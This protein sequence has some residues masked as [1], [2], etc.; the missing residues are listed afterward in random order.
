MDRRHKTASV[1]LHVVVYECVVEC[2]CV[3]LFSAWRLS[4]CLC[5]SKHNLGKYQCQYPI[6]RIFPLY[7]KPLHKPH[8]PHWLVVK[9]ENFAVL[10]WFVFT[11][12][13]NEQ[14]FDLLF[15]A[16]TTQG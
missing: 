3:C 9:I 4:K 12:D 14:G 10:L 8:V 15:F 7:R 5:N 11:P 1:C 2:A 13:D 6:D 16:A